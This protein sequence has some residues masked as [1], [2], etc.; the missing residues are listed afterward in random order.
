MAQSDIEKQ[1]DA[2]SAVLAEATTALQ[3]LVAKMQ[4]ALA[5][6]KAEAKAHEQSSKPR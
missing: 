6:T 3:A 4:R 5:E 2:V 1:L